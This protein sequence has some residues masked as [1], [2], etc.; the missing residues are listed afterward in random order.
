LVLGAA[1][2]LLQTTIR[3]V[4]TRGSE[5][6]FEGDVHSSRIRRTIADF[7]DYLGRAYQFPD[8]VVLLTGTGTVPPSDFTL[9]EADVVHIEI[10]GLGRLENTVTVV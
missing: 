7:A 2:D 9:H 8:G 5:T 6:M 1:T 3:I 4:I 10:D